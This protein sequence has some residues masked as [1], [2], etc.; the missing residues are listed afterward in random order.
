MEGVISLERLESNVSLI[1][2]IPY[3]F[4]DLDGEKLKRIQA[5]IREHREKLSK[6]MTA[7]HTQEEANG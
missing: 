6:E 1:S 2:L 4:Y 5:D 3:A 7:Q